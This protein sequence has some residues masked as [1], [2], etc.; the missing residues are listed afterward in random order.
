MADHHFHAGHDE[1][2]YYW[3]LQAAQGSNGDPERLRLL[4]RAVA[5]RTRVPN[6]RLSRT[7]LLWMLKGAAQSTA[8][9]RAELDA[10]EELCATSTP[11]LPRL[12]APSCAS[13]GCTCASPWGSASSP[14]PTPTKPFGWG[15]PPRPRGSTPL[16][17]RSR[18][19]AHWEAT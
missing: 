16:R 15:R 9:H 13:G 10:V 19:A 12:S 11:H 1:E 17:W 18:R 2:A 3:S 6:D 5:L 8:A 7:D 4:Q 14:G